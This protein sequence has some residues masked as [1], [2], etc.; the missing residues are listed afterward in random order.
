[1][2]IAVVS[3]VAVRPAWRGR[4]IAAGLYRRL[5]GFIKEIG[6]PVITFAIAGSAGE[7]IL[8]RAYAEAG[9]RVRSLGAY[10]KYAGLAR[11]EAAPGTEEPEAETEKTGTPLA[12][13]AW[14]EALQDVVAVCA[15][16]TGIL[17]SDPAPGQIRHYQQDPR[18]RIL[19]TSPDNSGAAWCVRLDI[20]TS[21]GP[22]AVTSID[23]VWVPRTGDV[24]ALQ[25]FLSK[26][27]LWQPHSPAVISL[28]SL[29]GFE[30]GDLRRIGIRQTGAPFHGYYCES[31][32]A[33][34]P[35]TFHG[36]SLEI[37]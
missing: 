5:L 24:T 37:V 3:F 25:T 15:A 27:T 22:G 36:T 18:P 1:M 10:L 2:D 4:G 29:Y 31:G 13:G 28:P 17:W 30:A 34:L 7:V 32:A 21:A 19:L 23:A 16:D 26:A 8:L 11:K 35:D 14:T 12:Q 33:S 6:V 20:H 9:F